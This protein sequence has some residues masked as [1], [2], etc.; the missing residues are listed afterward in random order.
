MKT[1]IFTI[2]FRIVWDKSMSEDILQDVFSPPEPSIKNLRAYIFQIAHNLAINSTKKQPQHVPLDAERWKMA[3]PVSDYLH[4]K[5]KSGE[6][7]AMFA[8]IRTSLF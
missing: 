7:S 5:Y 6:P 3:A 2:I 1:P 8:A 4:E